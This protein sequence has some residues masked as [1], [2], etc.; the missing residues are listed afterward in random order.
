[1]SEPRKTPIPRPPGTTRYTWFVGVAL[2]LAV[3]YFTLNTLTTKHASSTGPK[4]GRRMPPFAMPLALSALDGDA[5]VATRPHQGK[6]GSRPACQVRGPNILNVCQLWERGPV[7]LAFL[8]TRGGRC[9]DQLDRLQAIRHE[10]PTV[11]IAA[12]AV[13]GDRGDLRSDVRA[14]G[15]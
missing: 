8:A 13:R 6:A 1:M 12:V 9:E 10:F 15:W 4:V 11:Q 5:N 7:A 3:A 14:H 2:F